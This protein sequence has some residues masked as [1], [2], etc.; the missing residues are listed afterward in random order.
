METIICEKCG[1]VFDARDR[2]CEACG[3][4]R[5]T[6]AAREMPA[7][8]PPAPARACKNCNTPLGDEDNFCIACGT[9]AGA[10]SQGQ[11][12]D[13]PRPFW[14]ISGS[15]LR[16]FW[17]LIPIAVIVI[18][19]VLILI[20]SRKGSNNP[21][22]T[23]EAGTPEPTAA[24][25]EPATLPPA[26]PVPVTPAPATPEPVNELEQ[27]VLEGE[28][29]LYTREELIGKS[30]YELSILRNGMFALS[31][32]IFSR[33]KEVKAFFEACDWYTPYS[34]DDGKVRAKFNTFQKANVDLILALEREL[35]YR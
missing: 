11:G 12:E 13:S 14:E 2:F 29:R 20:F 22:T 17:Y 16:K 34:E 7:P 31:G 35:G 26:T 9:P 33:N 32:K 25:S 19:L 8:P 5:K 15:M 28:N 18:A 6:A 10:P 1:Y 3:A 27:L 4:I 23:P 24:I 21:S 30:A